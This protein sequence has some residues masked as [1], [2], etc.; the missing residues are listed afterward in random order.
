LSKGGCIKGTAA[1]FLPIFCKDAG[2]YTTKER[3]CY[4]DG[5]NAQG[6]RVSSGVYFYT[7]KAGNFI[8]TKKLAIVK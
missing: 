1:A 2:Y 5:R 3:A 4:W 6:E 8:A 7:I